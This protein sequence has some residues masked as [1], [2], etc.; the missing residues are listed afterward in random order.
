MCREQRDEVDVNELVAV[1]GEDVT[2]S[3]PE[4]GGELDPAAATEP[5][6]LLG[7][8]DLRAETVELLREELSLSGCA[9][10][11]HPLHPGSHEAPDLVGRERLA[12]DLDQRLGTA[13]RSIAEPLGLAAGEDDRFAGHLDGLGA[14]GLG[15]RVGG[16]SGRPIPS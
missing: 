12:G 9:R 5:L 14:R 7:D 2:G 13:A 15:H 3:R 11:D 6:G 10:D 4:A 8:D 16:R 1:Q